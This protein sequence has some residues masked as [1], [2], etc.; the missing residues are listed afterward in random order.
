M[1]RNERTLKFYVFEMQIVI[2]YLH[3]L[4]MV[5]NLIFKYLGINLE[6]S[7]FGSVLCQLLLVDI[8]LINI[9]MWVHL[10]CGDVWSI[11]IRYLNEFHVCKRFIN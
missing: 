2:R 3:N 7:T 10:V 6:S 9:Y 5:I 1:E 11:S 4:Y 8:V